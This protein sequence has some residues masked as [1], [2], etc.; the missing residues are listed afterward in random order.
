[1]PNKDGYESCQEIRAWEQE[2]SH[3]SIPIIALSANVLDDVWQ[4][5][6]KAGFNSYITKPLQFEELR[7]VMV[8]ILDPED[9]DAPLDFMGMRRE[10]AD[11]KKAKH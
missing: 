9:P 11:G 1:M 5:C 4:K 6:R 2:N 8:K 3:P 7:D 10:S